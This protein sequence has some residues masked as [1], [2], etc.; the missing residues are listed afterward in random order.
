MNEV[1]FFLRQ[2][3]QVEPLLCRILTANSS[4][5]TNVCNVV[6]FSSDK[7]TFS[8]SPV[9]QRTAESLSI[10]LPQVQS[11]KRHESM[12]EAS[13]FETE[14]KAKGHHDVQRLHFAVAI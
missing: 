5:S 3:L 9:K 8:R 14:T 1:L 11:Y 6:G 13:E 12:L 7:Y 4:G 10:D 2:L